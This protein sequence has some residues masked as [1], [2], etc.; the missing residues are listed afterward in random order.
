[1]TGRIIKAGEMADRQLVRYNP[2]D[3]LRSVQEKV[4]AASSQIREERDRAT[5]EVQRIHEEAAKRGYDAGFAKGSEEGR[6]AEQA[7]YQRKLE[8]EVAS[9]CTSLKDA[10][11]GVAARADAARVE[12]LVEWEE[13]AVE[14]VRAIASRV[15]RK[16]V[17]SDESTIRRTLREILQLVANSGKVVA[18]LHPADIESIQWPSNPLSSWATKQQDLEFVADETLT[19]GGCRVET[20]FSSIDATVETQIEKLLSEITPNSETSTPTTASEFE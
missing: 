10:M 20:E 6:A 15:A 3:A 4:E 18:Y 2:D 13:S 9:R 12:W 19:R 8:E 14:I 1:M 17:A 5:A 16:V 7:A 11:E